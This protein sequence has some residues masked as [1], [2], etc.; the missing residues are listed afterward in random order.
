MTAKLN[1]TN[2]DDLMKKCKVEYKE[3]SIG[4]NTRAYKNGS[5]IC[6]VYH[7]TLI[8][9]IDKSPEGKMFI[10]VLSGGWHT[11]TT[12]D[13]INAFLPYGWRLFQKDYAWYLYNWKNDTTA[14][15]FNGEAYFIDGEIVS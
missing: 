1:P 10:M 6:I 3:Y 2:Y 9:K 15:P 4:H 13:R 12:K 11:N 7:N 8:A 5:A 14:V